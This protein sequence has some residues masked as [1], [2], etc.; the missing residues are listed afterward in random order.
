MALSIS[1]RTLMAQGVVVTAAALG[2]AAEATGAGA[3]TPKNLDDVA[4]DVRF[5]PNASSVV[6]GTVGGRRS[7]MTGSFFGSTISGSLHGVAVD[8]HLAEKDQVPHG[9]GFVTTTG[10]SGTVG[11]V[12]TALS[13]VFD[14]DATFL[15]QHGRVTGTHHG[16]KVNV[17]V[18]PNTTFDDTSAV[19]V[20]GTFGTTKLSLVANLPVGHRGTVTGSVGGKKIHLNLTPT[21]A[22]G[23]AA[24]TR[25]SGRYSGPVDLLALLLGAI[26]FFDG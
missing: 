8:A 20:K 21:G 25:L 23:S 22:N 7:D 9:S 15:F 18:T 26:S 19:D 1:R 10:L 5:D 17:R 24:V 11:G 3:S 12:A 4:I 2:A 13:G 6:S 16:H 14:I